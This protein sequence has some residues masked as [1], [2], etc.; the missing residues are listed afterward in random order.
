MLKELSVK[1][2]ENKILGVFKKEILALI[3][4]SS[5]NHKESFQPVTVIG[6]KYI[7]KERTELERVFEIKGDLEILEKIVYLDE[8]IAGILKESRN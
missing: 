6:L 8:K 7:F 4:N 3:N 5:D 1:V 2:K